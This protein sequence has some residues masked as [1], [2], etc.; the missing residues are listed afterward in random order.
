MS[1]NNDLNSHQHF[2][3]GKYST[4]HLKLYTRSRAVME[5]LDKYFNLLA[6]Y[7]RALERAVT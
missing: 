1:L 3:C 5:L 6:N 2:I 4:A 7:L